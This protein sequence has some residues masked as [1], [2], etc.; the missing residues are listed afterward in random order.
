MPAGGDRLAFNIG[1]SQSAQS[2]FIAVANHLETLIAERDKEVKAAMADAKIDG[3]DSTYL[4][5]EQRWNLVSSNTVS[6]VRAL[7]D[8]MSDNDATAQDALSRAKAA[9]DAIA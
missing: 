6:I 4:A 2:N 3:A 7:R 9:V 8:A 1:D 5:K